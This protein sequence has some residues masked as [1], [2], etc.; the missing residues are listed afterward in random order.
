MITYTFMNKNT[1][2]FDVVMDRGQ[3]EDILNIRE[4]NKHLLPV[5]LSPKRN[6][7]MSRRDFNDWWSARRIPASRTDIKELLWKLKDIGLNELAEKSLGLSL[8]DQYW[9][10]PNKDITWKDVNFFSNEFSEDIGELLISGSWNSPD[11]TTDGVVKKKWK[12]ID[13]ERYLI[14]GSFSTEGIYQPQP[15]REVFASKLAKLLLEPFKDSENFVTPYHLIKEGDIV[16][17]ACPNFI[18]EG[19][20]YVAFNQINHTYKRLNHISEFNFCRE[21]YK[22]NKHVLDLTLILDYIL[23]NEDR[24]FGNFGIIRCAHTGEFLRPA[25]IFD[26]GACMF[27]DSMS[28]ISGKIESKPFSKSFEKQIKYV[29]TALYQDSIALVRKHYQD[30][31]AEV[32]A[33]SLEDNLRKERILEM[34]SM[35]IKKIS[36]M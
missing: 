24:H 4:E 30:I 21:F 31:F 15:F 16:F 22:E 10:R 19:T 17:S 6:M 36:T 1:E 20:E 3:A 18:T 8:S 27:F 26:T 2:L 9:I 13:G 11:N 35:Q 25:P 5:F 28:I 23:Y 14:K 32:F 12:I 29:N 7:K 34:T 33:T